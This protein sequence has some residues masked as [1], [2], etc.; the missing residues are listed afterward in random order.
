MKRHAAPI[1][2]ATLLFLLV[3]Y[4][5]SYFALVVPHGRAYVQMPVFPG[6]APLYISN[7]RLGDETPRAFFWPLERIDRKVRPQAWVEP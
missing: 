5:G 4:V 1:I 7:Y 2:A 6:S 3:L